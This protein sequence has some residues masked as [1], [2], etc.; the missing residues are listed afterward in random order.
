MNAMKIT[1]P[2]LVGIALLGQPATPKAPAAKSAAAPGPI[3]ALKFPALRD[4]RVPE[5]A[6][7]TLSNGIKVFLL[8]NHELP[9][10]SGFAVVR[11][12]NLFD[13]KDKVGLADMTGT[14][15]RQ[16]GTAKA[17]AT[18]LNEQ[19]ENIAASVEANIG[20]TSGRVSFNCLKE[21]TDEVLGVF[22]DVLT[23]P[24]FAADQLEIAKSREKSGISRRNDDPGEIAQREFNELLYGRSTPYGW[25]AEYSTIDAIKREDLV[26]FHQRYFFP[27][28]TLL[29]VYGDFS[30]DEMK[31]KLEQMFGTWRAEQPPVPAFPK[32]DTTPHPGVFLAAKNDVNQS[33]LRIGHLGGTL[34]DKDYPALEVMGSVLG[35]SPFTSRLGRAIRVER[36]YAYQVG[37]FWA[38]Q[39]NHPGV[40][41]IVSG[42]KSENTVDAIRV[43]QQEIDKFRSAPPT[44]EEVKSA[45]DKILNS[46]VFA[47]DSPSKTLNRLV[48]YEYFGY[49]KDFIFRY[50]KAIEAVTPADIQRV[51]REYLK[52]ENFTY[53]VTGKPA[54]FKQPLTALNL[55]V[56]EID[57][58]IP[59]PAAA[60]P[61]APRSAASGDQGKALLARAIVAMGG[62]KVAEVRDITV[63]Q[64]LDLNS[65]QG[66]LQAKQTN[67]WL[68]PTT[69]RQENELPFGKLVGFYD[70]TS[71]WMKT[72]QGEMPANGPVLAQMKETVAR[73]LLSLLRSGSI[74]GRTVNAVSAEEVEITAEGLTVRLTI[75]PQTGL[76]KKLSYNGGMGGP[77]V[78][79]EEIYNSFLESGGVK[80]PSSL[81]ILQGGN[82]F[83]EV[84]VSE[85]NFNS[86]LKTEDLA[87]KQ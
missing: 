53:V 22:R 81:T 71:G 33:T 83:A 34:A 68:L 32:V 35:G 73:E 86:G 61:A 79:V 72:P 8:E 3:A 38:P 43:I 20:E 78:A 52:P 11:T 6:T 58:T 70:G 64:T 62:A 56:K 28:N 85:V 59:A 49:P 42:T 31:S 4:V 1:V 7:L 39:Y 27:K 80:Y 77:P 21:N 25:R 66:A 14:V 10:V 45:K 5:P 19:L 47:F 44:A 65:P 40:F 15:M 57:L 69:F 30:I 41:G 74:A 24:A 29:A 16:G 87:K 54:D 55:P 67:R 76:P 46:F 60:R 51:A 36:G 2:F 84:K 23:A 26:A 13:P 9:V 17:A 12:G 82:K 75:D 37:A 50:Q 18:Q 48:N 63:V